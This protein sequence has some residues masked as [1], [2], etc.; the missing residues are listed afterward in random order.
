[1]SAVLF[2]LTYNVQCYQCGVVFGL[3]QGFQKQRVGDHKPFYCPNGHSQWYTG[4]T[5]KEREIDR[6]KDELRRTE[7]ARSFQAARAQ[8]HAEA[9]ETARRQAAAA[10]GVVTK[11]KRRI[12]RGVC[13]C[14][15][16]Y[17]R[18]LHQHMTTQHPDWTNEEKAG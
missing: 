1:M 11:V 6:L 9:A 12:G 4:K 5:D 10:R 18:E 3:E 8:Q 2:A 17:F 13:P 15:N 7:N 14:C 16:R